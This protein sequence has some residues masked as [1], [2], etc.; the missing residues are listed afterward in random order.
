[1]AKVKK[2]TSFLVSSAGSGF[3]YCNR[4]NRKKIRGGK[5]LALRKYDPRL[6][7]HVIFE[8]GKLKKIQKP[9]DPA[10]AIQKIQEAN[11]DTN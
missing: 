10:K 4:K 6:R 3:F 11:P 8:E 9:F 1:M 7:K 2:E 5:K